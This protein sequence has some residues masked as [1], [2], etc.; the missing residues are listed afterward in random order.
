[1]L[2]LENMFEQQQ[3]Y[4]ANP[5][6]TDNTLVDK[7]LEYVGELSWEH[8]EIFHLRFG[9]R[10]SYRKIADRLGYKS[11][12]AIQTRVDAIKNHVEKRLNESTERSS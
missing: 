10:M 2:F 7:V 11:P 4:Y 9:E 1:M 8:Q 5:K 3:D 6:T 12:W